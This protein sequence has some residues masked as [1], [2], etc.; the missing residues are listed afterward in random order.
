MSVFIETAIR[1]TSLS[2]FS[3]LLSTRVGEAKNPGPLDC[4]LNICNGE[5]V[6]RFSIINPTAIHNKIGDL[7]ELNSNCLCL[8]ETSATQAVQDTST[9]LA[10][11]NDYRM[12]WS[13]PVASRMVLEYD[14]PIY[15]GESSGTACM[16]NLPSRPSNIS[17]PEDIAASSRIMSCV[18]RLGCIDVLVFSF[19]GLTGSSL[20]ARKANDYLLASIYHLATQVRMP[21]LV[22]GDF[23]IRP[24]VLPSYELFSKKGFLDAF[25]FFESKHGFALPPTCNGKT[26]NDTFLIDPV[27]MP[28][29]HDI[30]VVEGCIFDSHSP[31]NIDFRI[32]LN[33]P[34]HLQWRMPKSWKELGIPKPLIQ[35]AYERH[36]ASS[37]LH[38][39][40]QDTNVDFA[41]TMGKWSKFVEKIVGEAVKDH[42]QM[43]PVTQTHST[44]PKI[45][46]GRCVER[47]R[48]KVMVGNPTKYS[49]QGYN[50]NELAFTM[51]VKQKTKQVRRLEGL[52]RAMNNYFTNVGPLP[53]YGTYCQWKGEWQ[54]IL[55]A[56]GYG[57][58]WQKWIL[59][60]DAVPC[61]P[62]NVPQKNFVYDALQITRH[63][64]NIAARREQQL[65]QESYH[66]K[67]AFDRSDNFLR[68]TY[69][70]LKGHGMP[71]VKNV[72]V[73]KKCNA[74]LCR[75]SHGR[76]VVKMTQDKID[77]HPNREIHFGECVAELLEQ[78]GNIAILHHT[79]GRVPTHG[80]LSQDDFACTPIEL[81]KE[82][83]RFWEPLWQRD[84]K[85]EENESRHWENFNAIIEQVEVSIPPI[86]IDLEDPQRWID[87][88]KR[89]KRDKAIGYDGWH[90]EDLQSLPESAIVHLSQIFKKL[91]GHNFNQN[92]MQARV[93]LLSK[94]KEV[95]HMGHCRPVTILGTLYRLA[96][97][98]IADQLLEAWSHRLPDTIS[99]GV[100][101]RG[102][103]MLMYVHQC[104]VE[105]CII[106]RQQVGGF[107]LD[108][109]KAF[110]YIPRKPLR[111]MFIKMGVPPMYIDCWLESL[112]SL[113]RLPQIG[114]HL[115]D[116][117]ESS[118]GVPEGDAMSVCSMVALAFF[119]HEHITQQLR[120]VRVTIYADNWS[121]LTTSQ[122]ENFKALQYTL[123]FVAAARMDID[124]MKS[125]AWANGADFKRSLEYLQFLLPNGECSIPVAQNARELGVLIKYSKKSTLGPLAE[126]IK[127]A[128]HRLQKLTW[129]STALETKGRLIQTS[130]WPYCFYGA[131]GTGI[132]ENHFCKLRRAVANIFCS[133]HKQASSWIANHML[134]G[135]FQDPLLYIIC[136]CLCLLRQL[137]DCNRD[138]AVQVL[139]TAWTYHVTHTFGPGTALRFYIEKAG[140]YINMEGEIGHNTMSLRKVKIF[141]L[142][143]REI[144]QELTHLW[145]LTVVATS[146]HRKGISLTRQ[147]HQKNTHKAL[148]D[149]TDPELKSLYINVTGGFQSGVIKKFA[150]MVMRVQNFALFV[151]L[152]T[153]SG[154]G[155]L[156]VHISND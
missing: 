31:L 20:E 44:L 45:Y 73:T 57:N 75:S 101:R 112:K 54:T 126:K 55:G 26:R 3:F 142:S 105:Q 81:C 10:G 147:I 80:I 25:T 115:G 51:K 43:D 50:P 29:I 99:G 97:K 48:V 120:Q 124:F 155:L 86:K 28:Y 64:C 23:N 84:T 93:I 39:I 49:E 70:I 36:F 116:P 18:V 74:V 100:P 94:I 35:A 5:S 59:G 129:V 92:Y 153:R 24:E 133:G 4:D 85:E 71:P 87:T 110:N 125:W 65:R 109:I 145:G 32:P 56:R 127:G 113:T 2:T 136:S 22:G 58:S 151:M 7:V 107:V 38:E 90:N 76:L 1:W 117:V 123:A 118:T 37:G 61:V 152:L 128:K 144:R 119:Y 62:T 63:D 104:K 135:S 79:T 78:K 108:L 91:W 15:R 143:P 141:E 13:S 60:F 130:V 146:E 11:K 6:I 69:R 96:T 30:H 34:A 53:D 68:G 9:I 40:I 95:Q 67:M 83:T 140:W 33:P 72:T 21:V 102:A 154:I 19:Y 138:L 156:N 103:R 88:I 12:F 122:K 106:T 66:L 121:W 17:L 27:L 16:T 134:M 114:P 111:Q 98:M 77:L 52:Y 42:H 139:T 46:Q 137:A 131:E 41:E 148:R 14:R 8:A 82:F 132:G 47:K 89:L 150:T 149:F